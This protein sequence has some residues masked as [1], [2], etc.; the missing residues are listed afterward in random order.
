MA[1]VRNIGSNELPH[2]LA[3]VYEQFA[4][5]YGPFRNQVAVFAHAPAALTH[6]MSLLMEL[7]AA[8][9][10]AQARWSWPS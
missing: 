2:D 5:Q 1:R 7:R 4:E 9:N 8:K 3:V 6:L 10:P